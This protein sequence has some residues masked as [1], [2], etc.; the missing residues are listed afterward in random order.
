MAMHTSVRSFLRPAGLVL[1]LVTVREHNVLVFYQATQANSALLFLHGSA[2][3]EFM[4]F[5]FFLV[6]SHM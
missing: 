5:N 2:Q 3:Q 6:N 4:M 1:R